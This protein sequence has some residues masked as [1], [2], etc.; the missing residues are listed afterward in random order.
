M[1]ST[2]DDQIARL[3]EAG[4][5][6]DFASEEGV[7]K[8]WARVDVLR[9]ASERGWTLDPSGRIP[10]QNRP[11]P[12]PPAVMRPGVVLTDKPKPTAPAAVR[13]VRTAPPTTSPGGTVDA[14]KDK[15]ATGLRSEHPPIRKAAAKAN[16]ALATLDRL[17]ADWDAKELARQRIEELEQQLAEAKA[18]LRGTATAPK[19][20]VKGEHAKA[21]EWARA[22][23]IEVPPIG[24]VPGPVLEQWRT[25]A[26]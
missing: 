5:S 17:L 4:Y 21:R 10:R 18:A 23:G 14:T 20:A 12:R 11:A 8:G 15:I 9:V 26:A 7:T 16:E 22:N 2:N 1:T 13:P 19:T 6:V 24:R 3:L 25:S